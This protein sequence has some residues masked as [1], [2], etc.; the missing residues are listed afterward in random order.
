MR[1]GDWKILT[2]TDL[3]RFELYNL[4]DDVAESEDLAAAEPQRLEAMKQK[5]IEL[6]SRIEAEGPDWWK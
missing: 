1:E 6:N 3:S 5:L 2:P 4:R